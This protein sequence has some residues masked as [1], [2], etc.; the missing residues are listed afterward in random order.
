MKTRGFTLI[1]LLA[2]IIIL[3]II[4]LIASP[5]IIGL[6]D[7]A[8]KK[9]FTT[10]ANNLVDVMED[11]CQLQILKKETITTTY[12]FDDGVISPSLNIKGAL[13]INGTAIVDSSC[14]VVLSVTNGSF[15]ATKTMTTEDIEVVEGSQ[16]EELYPV[17]ANGTAIYFNPVTGV[18]CTSAEA[19][20]TTGTKTG[21]MKWHTFNDG[22]N[23]SGTINMILDHN[24]TSTIAWNSSASTVSGPNEILTRLQSDTSSWA[25]VPTRTDSYSVSNG[26]ST[27]TINY[28]GYKARIISA[29]EVAMITGNTS[30]NETTS[31][32]SNY[33]FFDNNST[34]TPSTYTGKYSWLYNYTYNCTN[35]GCSVADNNLFGYW[36]STSISGTVGSAWSVRYYS[37][38]IGN[39][40]TVSSSNAYGLRPV[41]TISKNV[42]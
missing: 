27:Y 3:S 9:A 13:P 1:E 25:G 38:L 35:Y 36:A 10:T 12:K 4:A 32:G 8:R 15:T 11:K 31:L 23:T 34:S 33:F 41:I 5:I 39:D 37:S 14:N 26:S 29:N 24:T 18:T 20:S 21:C 30:F 17:Y 22:G 7:D 19:V 6:I 42:L 2:V 16:V 40:T 28:S